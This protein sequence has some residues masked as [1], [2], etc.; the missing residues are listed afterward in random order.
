MIP[1]QYNG[2]FIYYQIGVVSYG[3][4][5]IKMITFNRFNNLIM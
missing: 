3:I 1:Q 5:K 4:G 2:Q